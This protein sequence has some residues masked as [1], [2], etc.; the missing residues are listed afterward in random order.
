M[1]GIP[2]G[3]ILGLL[4][5]NIFLCD[6]LLI[7]S[8]T[9]FASYADDNTSNTLGQYI[10]DVIG[11]LENDFVKLFKWFSNNNMKVNKDKCHFL[12]RKKVRVTIKIG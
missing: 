11:T 6:L 2:Q 9:E 1:F 3:S 8:K 10:D 5:F 4:L 7:V 12:L